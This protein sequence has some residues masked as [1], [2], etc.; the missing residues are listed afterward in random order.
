MRP[1]SCTLWKS[2]PI[3][4]HP[5]YHVSTFTPA[6]K[7]KNLVVSSTSIGRVNGVSRFRNSSR[8][9]YGVADACTNNRYTEHHQYFS[10]KAKVSSQEKHHSFKPLFQEIDEIMGKVKR[11]NEDNFK[12]SDAYNRRRRNDTVS[13]AFETKEN[14]TNTTLSKDNSKLDFTSFFDTIGKH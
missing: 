7:L 9:H 11:N 4:P 14:K 13:V 2:K 5:R 3:L 8:C 1:S 6:S 12:H 10:T